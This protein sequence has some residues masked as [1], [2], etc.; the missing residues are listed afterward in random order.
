V[1]VTHDPVSDGA[2]ALGNTQVQP[3]RAVSAHSETGPASA[4]SRTRSNARKPGRL[5]PFMNEAAQA[6]ENASSSAAA[7]YPTTSRTKNQRPKRDSPRT[8]AAGGV[9]KKFCTRT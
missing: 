9:T 7:R 8:K 1:S 2:A 4:A 6:K 5:V 3:W